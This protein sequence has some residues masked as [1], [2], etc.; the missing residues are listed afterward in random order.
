MLTLFSVAA[1]F[2]LATPA[3][4]HPGDHSRFAWREL[5][6]HLFEPDHLVFA[7]LIVITGVLAYRLGRRAG[8]RQQ[9][10]QDS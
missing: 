7:A 2:A 8:T 10:R 9:V 5:A 4:A 1:L 3:W 6:D